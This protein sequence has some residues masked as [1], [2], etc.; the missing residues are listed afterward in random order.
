[1]SQSGI[2]FIGGA[3]YSSPLD[4]TSEKKFRLLKA[5]GELF[6]IGFSKDLRPRQFNEHAHF[7]LMPNLPISLLRYVEVFVLGPL[8]VS[9]LIFRHG[10]Q[11]LVTQSPYEGLAGAMAKKIAACFGRKVMLVVE[12]HGDF[13]ESLFMQ[14]RILFPWLHRYIM[15][16]VAGFT[17]KHADSLRAVSNS[18]REQLKQWAPGKPIFKFVAWT[19]IEAF[20]ETGIKRDRPFS[21]IVLY[22]GVLIP[23]KGI[24]HLISAFARIAQEFPHSR[25]IIAGSADN[26][27]YA[28]QLKAQLKEADLNG[29]VEFVD[30]MP[31]EEL[32]RLMLEACLLVLPSY[33]EG[34][35]R[36]IYEA[37]AAG[38]PVIASAVSGIPD[39][40][41]DGT[42][43][44]LVPP[45]DE[46]RLTE[47]IRWM[48]A[49]PNDAYEMGHRGRA[50]AEQLF[51][52]E[53]FVAAYH[54]V[55]ED[56]EP[57]Q[58]NN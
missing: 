52:T 10:V 56:H 19:D 38:L 43:G 5:I 58:R 22:A 12:S 40:V 29:R 33:S 13:E 46:N 37:M 6:V 4:A 39:V 54:R 23:R 51:S 53:A 27:S 7:Y 25:L 41:Q 35:P 48:L 45:G 47:Q 8:I 3:R 42:T 18:T 32:A 15:R 1:M 34:L 21:Q 24:H 36:V 9:W 14:R 44:F 2:C 16:H 57:A 30:N 26:R 11:V 55:F 50:V 28:A 49:H 20:L 17:L 31:Q